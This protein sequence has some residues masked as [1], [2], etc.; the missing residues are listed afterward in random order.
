MNYVLKRV[1]MGAGW[2]VFLVNI[3]CQPLRV[4]KEALILLIKLPACLAR[5]EHIR[6]VEKREMSKGDRA[7]RSTS[8]IA[9]FACG[10]ARAPSER[11]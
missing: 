11:A 10:N 5:I 1:R 7:V 8:R 2:A 3:R 6:F 4:I 9:E